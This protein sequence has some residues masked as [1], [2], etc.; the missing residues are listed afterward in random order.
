MLHC[1]IENNNNGRFSHVCLFEK[2]IRCRYIYF[3]YIYYIYIYLYIII[4]IFIIYSIMKG[5]DKETDNKT[6]SAVSIIKETDK[7]TDIKKPAAT[8]R[9]GALLRFAGE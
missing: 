2:R 1:I 5:T 8:E 9:N 6:L 7:E 4:Y 3:I